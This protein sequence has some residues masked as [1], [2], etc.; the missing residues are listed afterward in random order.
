MTNCKHNHAKRDKLRSTLHEQ[1][2]TQHT[3]LQ[4]TTKHCN[5]HCNQMDT[6]CYTI[7]LTLSPIMS[8]GLAVLIVSA[9]DRFDLAVHI[10]HTLSSVQHACRLLR[11][12]V[13]R[14]LR[15]Y[16]FRFPAKLKSSSKM[17]PVPSRFI[18]NHRK[19][20]KRIPPTARLYFQQKRAPTFNKRRPPHPP[21]M[22][23]KHTLLLVTFTLLNTIIGNQHL[24]RAVPMVSSLFGISDGCSLAFTQ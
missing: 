2:T 23:W 18:G 22:V 19:N 24:Q 6:F 14:L 21:S 16:V 4:S 7:L 15:R 8:I 12:Y 5:H 3:A 17:F 11:R 13:F 1:R 20:H 10:T 9:V